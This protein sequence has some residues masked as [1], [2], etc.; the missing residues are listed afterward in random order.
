MPLSYKLILLKV[1]DDRNYFV[2]V[3]NKF[4]LEIMI[5]PEACHHTEN[6]LNK[7]KKNL[8]NRV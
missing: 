6:V 5:F 7:D 4:N 2:S 3:D 8:K 1:L